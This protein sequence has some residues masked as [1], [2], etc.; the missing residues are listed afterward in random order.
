M[1]EQL[2]DE[3]LQTM[4]VMGYY[5]LKDHGESWRS[6]SHEYYM[7]YYGLWRDIKDEIRR[8]KEANAVHYSD[9]TLTWMIG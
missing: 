5:A 4:E 2:T 9:T 7:R 1:F 8:R 3:Q 6:H